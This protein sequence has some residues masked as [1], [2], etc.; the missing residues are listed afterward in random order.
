MTGSLGL[1]FLLFLPQHRLVAIV[2][3]CANTNAHQVKVC[4]AETVNSLRLRHLLF[5]LYPTTPHLAWN[6]ISGVLAS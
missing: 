4:Q 1:S 3:A 5:T 2:S 6:S